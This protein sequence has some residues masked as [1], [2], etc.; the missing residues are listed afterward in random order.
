MQHVGIGAKLANRLFPHHCQSALLETDLI[1][2][3]AA[4][5]PVRVL[6][7]KMF[8]AGKTAIATLVYSRLFVAH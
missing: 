6:E 4:G 1:P 5:A 3:S 8:T 7:N 2:P